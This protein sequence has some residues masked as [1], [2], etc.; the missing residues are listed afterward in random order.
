[1]SRS[2]FVVQQLCMLGHSQLLPES[3]LRDCL[4]DWPYNHRDDVVRR[5]YTR[6]Y[7]VRTFPSM[8]WPA[9]VRRLRWL[10]DVEWHQQVKD[11][12]WCVSV[13]QVFNSVV[14]LICFYANNPIHLTIDK[15]SGSLLGKVQLTSSPTRWTERTACGVD[16][17]RSSYAVVVWELLARLL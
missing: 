10:D 14:E 4:Y 11:D 3:W 1:M 9:A 16:V 7:V 5:S 2:S 6:T 15:D 17:V 8:L 13:W 12:V